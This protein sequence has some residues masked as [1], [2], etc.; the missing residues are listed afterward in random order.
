M[1]EEFSFY[2]LPL[3]WVITRM[4]RGTE[5]VKLSVKLLSG[6]TLIAL[7]AVA[8][9]G[10]SHSA[11]AAVDAKVY[12]TNQASGFTT[13]PSTAV[14]GRTSATTV[15]GTYNSTIT[16]G[17]AARDIVPNSNR[18]I[19]T[20]VDSDLNTTSNISSAPATVRAHHGYPVAPIDTNVI[21]IAGIDF[22]D[23]GDQVQITLAGSNT[24]PII[25]DISTVSIVA[26]GQTAVLTNVS[27]KAINFA[28]D[29]TNPAIITIG[30]DFVNGTMPQGLDILY[31]S[32]AI[33]MVTATI[34]S[35][36]DTNGSVV[37]LTETGRNTGRFEGYVQVNERTA[38][39]TTGVNGGATGSPATIP[40]IGGPITV[41]FIDAATSG[42]ATN[43]VRTESLSIDITPPSV[44]IT[45]PTTASETQIRLPTFT[46]NVTDSE[47]GLDISTFGLFIDRNNDEDN[48]TPVIAFGISNST[49]GSNGTVAS[50]D[51]TAFKDGVGTLPFSY[52]ETVAL[53]TGPT[54]PDHIVDFQTRQA[55]TAGNYGYSDADTSKDLIETTGRHGNQ[56]HTLKI[57]VIIPQMT[58]AETG[59]D[60]D[61]SIPTPAE[62]SNVRDSLVVKF[63]GN[64]KE[65]TVQATDFQVTLS[66]VGGATII[67]ASVLVKGSD[68]YLDLDV[69]IPSD[70]K[71]TVKLQGT[72]SDI[73]GNTRDSAT[74]AAVDRLS[75]VVTITRSGGTGTGT[76]TEAAD[77]LT[78]GN[79]TVTVSSD[80]GLQGPPAYTVTDITSTG[81]PVSSVGSV[82]DGTLGVAQ[83]SSTWALVVTKGDSPDGY[84]AVSVLATDSAGNAS[85]TGKNDVNSFRLDKTLAIPASSPANLGTTTQS[86]PFLTT[87][88]GAAAEK[89]SVTI[90]SA[91]LDTLDV[92]ASVIAS[93]DNKTFFFQPT[94]ALTNEE[95]T[96]EVKS[97]DAAGNKRT[98][99]TKFT[100]SDRVDFAI[101]LFAG[102]NS[103]SFPSNPLDT[104]VNSVLSNSGVKQV[105]A[106]DATTPSQ[107]WR[108]AS[109]VGSAAYTSQTEPG[110]TSI[111]AGPGYWVETANFEDQKVALEGPTGP[112]DARPGLTTIATGNGWNLVGVVDQSR[113]QTQAT[114]KAGILQRPNAAGGDVPVTN[115]T[116][117]DTVNSD[118]AYT[119]DTVTSKFRNQ[120]TGDNLIIGTGIWVFISPQSNGQ[121]PHIV[122]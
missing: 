62:K 4:T 11:S 102:W 8:V 106:Y 104:D 49:I 97:V 107:P 121:L 119:F 79:M 70:N 109:K 40:A 22:A 60:W 74:V 29:G 24:S 34:K 39:F 120:A 89:S 66:G 57:D 67:P 51:L 77:S 81:A 43:V 112:G 113:S 84:R 114:N 83:T 3:L 19:V 96:Y 23:A 103:V 26:S 92:T 110:L 6:L 68:V 91:T 58:S 28:G 18:F 56:P 33:N 1:V 118:R 31:K 111:T 12:V 16:S 37:T 100:K 55:D 105:V 61:A 80:E 15:Y 78:S 65:S 20:V 98:T 41:T 27:V 108:I 87:D 45:S 54:S 122:P 46:G 47:S 32:S 38:E 63:D 64:I 50:I 48:G 85:T 71:P 5:A 76:T 82:N 13:E 86:N 30:V 35:V 9:I 17:A 36:V 53:P 115:S 52:K 88:Y 93:A 21:S 90:T 69:T 42:T 95:H 73:A 72:I 101:G 14:A 7:V 2:F 44:T 10:L 117:F 25:G 75:P 99:T 94:T 59:R 116:Y